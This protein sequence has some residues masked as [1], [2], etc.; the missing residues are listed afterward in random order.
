[1]LSKRFRNTGKF[2]ISNVYIAAKV[3]MSGGLLL[4]GVTDMLLLQHID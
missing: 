1:M 3:W 4:V 2:K